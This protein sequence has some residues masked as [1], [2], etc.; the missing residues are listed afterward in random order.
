MSEVILNL[1][2]SLNVDKMHKK[3]TQKIYLIIFE[4]ITLI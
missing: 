1:L 3:F 4:F 2:C